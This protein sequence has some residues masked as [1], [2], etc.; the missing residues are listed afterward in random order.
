[1]LD[2]NATLQTNHTMVIYNVWDVRDVWDVQFIFNQF[3]F[4][5]IKISKKK[6]Q[7][8]LILIYAVFLFFFFLRKKRTS[9]FL[10]SDCVARLYLADEK[11]SL[12]NDSLFCPFFRVHVHSPRVLHAR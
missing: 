4:K 12:G 6:T 3:N 10:H 7:K 5:I 8:I 11:Y 9:M 1:M 2:N